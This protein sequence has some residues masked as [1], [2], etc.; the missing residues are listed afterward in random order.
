MATIVGPVL[1][2]DKC[3]IGTSDRDCFLDLLELQPGE[4]PLR[5]NHCDCE[6]CHV[7]QVV[8]LM[9]S[10]DRRTWAVAT[11]DLPRARVDGYAFSVGGVVVD[12]APADRVTPRMLVLREVSLVE[13]SGSAAGFVR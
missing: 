7:G 6:G 4:L 5:L 12:H 11:T 2:A 3:S 8:D 1:R 10:D 9:R 13:R